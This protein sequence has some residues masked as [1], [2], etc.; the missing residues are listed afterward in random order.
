M[1]DG[2]YPGGLAV[3]AEEV[4]YER[5][6]SAGV[7]RP[8]AARRLTLRLAIDPA[9]R[10][11]ALGVA[12]ACAD[13]GVRFAAWPLLD[14]RRGRWAHVG[15]AVAFADHARR[16]ADAL[17]LEGAS[18]AE[19]A[20]DLEPPI[21][22]VRAVLSRG[23]GTT[24]A[25][26]ARAMR[27][28]TSPATH[29]AAERVFAELARDLAARGASVVA[30]AAPMIALDPGRR[31]AGWQR[32]LGTPI[33]AAPWD[34]VAV[35]AYSSLF[36][37]Y[38]RGVVDRDDAI[39]LLASIARLS[40]ERWPGRA[41]IAL[42]V[43]GGGALGDERPYRSPWELAEDVAIARAAAIEHLSLF[44]LDG[45]IARP[46]LEAWLDAFVAPDEVPRD[47]RSR[48]SLRAGAIVA[49]GRALAWPLDA[50]FAL[51]R[52]LSRRGAI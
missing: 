24:L 17:A 43:V 33:D 10:S 21:D 16:V 38:G 27:S 51:R 6:A 40:R 18:L 15:N 48:R 2:A 9:R 47:R 32:A 25:R 1:A 39:G 30:T 49:A 34:R 4:P 45:A 14:D 35:M 52:K 46:P 8:L 11:A 3:W 12:R 22:A 19:V 13:H 5:L 31:T 23:S 26:A 28:F 42:G 44:G 50:T 36:E 37:G 7:L 29:G 41:E 20:I